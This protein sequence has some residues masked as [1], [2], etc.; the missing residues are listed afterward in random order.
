[1][2]HVLNSRLAA[3]TAAALIAAAAT[4]GIAV[5][6]AHTPK[7]P[8]VPADVYAGWSAQNDPLW[9]SV[10]AG[11]KRITDSGAA[12]DLTCTPSGNKFTGVDG[13]R[14]IPV[15]ANR[16]FTGQGAVPLTTNPDGSKYEGSDTIT[17][18][19]SP[20][21]KTITG[22]WTLNETFIPPPG[23]TT[24]T[25]TCTSGPIAFKIHS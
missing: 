11:G 25:D 9:F 5:G 23:S 14:G 4:T 8:P 20:D 13:L 18:V 21:H 6:K 24:T 10:S 2:V 7:A 19:I 3:T 15:A 12:I 1:M 17:G 16:H 22:T